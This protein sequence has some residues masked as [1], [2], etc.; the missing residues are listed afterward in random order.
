M[1]SRLRR[2]QL[3]MPSASTSTFIRPS[4][5]M[6][7]LSHSMKVR[8]SMAALPTG[9]V[10]SRRKRVSTKP[11]TCWERWRGKPISSLASATAWRIAALSGSSPAWRM[12]SSATSRSLMP[13]IV[14]DNAAVTSGV[15]PNTLPT[16]PMALEIDVDVGRLAAVLGD[17]AGEQEVALVRID[18]GDAE[19]IA[20]CAVRRRTAALAQ[21][22]LL[23]AAREGDHVVHGEEV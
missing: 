20:D 19:A 16:S 4:V 23:A 14:L 7:S 10:S 22:L 21:D 12:F 1:R 18:R 15:R 8:S 3:S 5:S 9:T 13:Q 6:S 2:R 11:P 17:E